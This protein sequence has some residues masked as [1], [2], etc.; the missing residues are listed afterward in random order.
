MV[1]GTA[2]PAVVLMWYSV[3][4]ADVHWEGRWGVGQVEGPSR[5]G[6]EGTPLLVKGCSCWGNPGTGPKTDGDVN[7]AGRN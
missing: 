5:L 7:E 3:V 6:L 4:A 1:W 2:G